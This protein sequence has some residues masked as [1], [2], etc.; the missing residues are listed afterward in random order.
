MRV[1]SEKRQA[2]QCVKKRE[3]GKERV[4]K[5]RPSYYGML[6]YAKQHGTKL[7]SLKMGKS[8]QHPNTTHSMHQNIVC[9]NFGF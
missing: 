4:T 2:K 7:I 9:F 8:T 3:R 5:Y 1:V 6:S